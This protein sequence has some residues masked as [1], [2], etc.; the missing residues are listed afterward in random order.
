MLCL[1]KAAEP[2]IRRFSVAFTHPTF[3][4]VV[5]LIVGAVLAQRRRTVTAMLD[6]LGPLAGGHF[7]DFHRVLSCRVWSCWPLAKV[8]AGLVLRWVPADQP[9]ILAVDDTAVSRNGRHVFGQGKHLDAV[10]STHRFKAW[11]WGHKWVVLAVNIKFR[12]ATR[13]WALPVLCALY[14]TVELDRQDNRRHRTP[15]RLGMQ[16]AAALIHW[17]PER[18]FILV[19]DGGY[20]SH[21]LA[22]FCHRHRRHLTLVSRCHADARLYDPPPARRK[23]KGGRPRL[24]GRK[25]Q[26]PSKAAARIKPRRFTVGWYGGQTRRVQ[27]ISDSGLWYKAGSGAA[28]PI[29][30][31]FVHDVT[32]THRDEYLY[33]TDPTLKP[34]QI[35]S[36]FTSRWSIEVTFQELR[37]HLG[38]TT[39]RNW[40]RHSVLRTTPCLMGLFSLLC[41]SFARLDGRKTVRPQTK[42]W[43]H[44]SECTFSDAITHIRRLCWAQVFAQGPAAEGVNKLP[45]RLRLLLLD[46]LSRAP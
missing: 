19:G 1:L 15:T 32:G 27:L 33:S 14:R 20:A 6:V 26:S 42:P 9:V 4:R 37:A 45:R 29:R 16:L 18:K 44:R 2:L 5:I 25:R 30:W 35:V 28:V 3:Q 11:L 7:S 41:L 36:Y 22:K 12:F 40:C 24:R 46:Q 43:H 21:Q 17:F 39:L 34:D 8:L 23:N 13:A 31:A 38:L 10:R